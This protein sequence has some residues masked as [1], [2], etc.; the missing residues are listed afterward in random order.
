MT[1]Y[2]KWRRNVGISMWLS[3][4]FIS[5]FL[6]IFLITQNSNIVFERMFR[7]YFE[8]VTTICQEHTDTHTYTH[9]QRKKDMSTVSI[10]RWKNRKDDDNYTNMN[11][12]L[13]CC[14]AIIIEQ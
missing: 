10:E 6:V 9:T 11:I 14:P 8:H 13:T 4:T 12:V 2:H 1:G 7:T 3:P 5:V